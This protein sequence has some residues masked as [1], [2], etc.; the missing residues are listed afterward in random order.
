MVILHLSGA[1][2]KRMTFHCLP[3]RRQGLRHS[4]SRSRRTVSLA[5]SWISARLS[6]SRRFL[7]ILYQDFAFDLIRRELK[8]A[9]KVSDKLH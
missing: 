4:S 3:Q 6:T 1:L 7:R 8:T 5:G 2:T 9:Y